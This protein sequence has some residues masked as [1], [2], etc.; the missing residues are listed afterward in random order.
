MTLHPLGFFPGYG[1]EAV[2]NLHVL[3]KTENKR[4]TDNAGKLLLHPSVIDAYSSNYGEILGYRKYFG[5]L[6]PQ[7]RQKLPIWT[8]LTSGN[9]HSCNVN[10]PTR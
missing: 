10:H 1:P 6:E 7:K 2:Q 9:A 4:I 5:F 8:R 3:A